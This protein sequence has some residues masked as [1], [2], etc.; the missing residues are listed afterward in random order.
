MEQTYVGR[1]HSDNGVRTVLV[2]PG[3]TKLHVVV[4]DYPVHV[5]HLDRKNERF[6]TPI[7]YP[8]PRCVRKMLEFAKHGN[9]TAG[10]R[11][12]LKECQ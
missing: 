5:V 2:K 3:R 12:L 8:V 9:A 11:A 6:I 7:E 10:A 1:W 4:S